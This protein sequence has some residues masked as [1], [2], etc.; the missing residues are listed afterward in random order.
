M[1]FTLI[2]VLS[3]LD[4]NAG[5]KAQAIAKVVETSPMLRGI[6]FEER[7]EL[8][9]RFFLE[10]DLPD[11][12]FREYNTTATE[13]NPVVEEEYKTEINQMADRFKLDPKLARVRTRENPRY[14][15]GQLMKRFRAFSLNLKRN[16]L[17]RTTTAPGIRG[18]YGWQQEYNSASDPVIIDAAAAGTTIDAL[19]VQ[20]FL[21]LM[22]ELTDATLGAPGAY[23]TNRNIM[24]Q[25][26]AKVADANNV[27]LQGRWEWRKVET[28]P[29]VTM[30]MGFWE[31]TPFIPVDYDAT[32]TEIME[33][34]EPVPNGATNN[35][36]SIVAVRWDSDNCMML[37]ENRQGPEVR[38]Y[39]EGGL[40][41]YE[42]D[43]GIGFE[44]RHPRAS[45]R[46]RGILEN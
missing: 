8:T 4:P 17:G 32:R 44:Q 41:V 7:P 37:Q 23:Y 15:D 6:P 40:K 5:V 24:R 11:I 20:A 42:T 31:D 36:S 30:R 14:T 27:A 2:D 1:A 10:G 33:F 25:I 9:S 45:A 21:E 43:W 35:S 3:E 18:L 28:A 13:S 22:G 26:D 46:L 29:N 38:E 34:D 19:S 12:D 39:M 16:I